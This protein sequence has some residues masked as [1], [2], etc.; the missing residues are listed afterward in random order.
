MAC[1]TA[2]AVESAMNQG[3]ADICMID[4]QSCSA[5]CCINTLRPVQR[6]VS[7]TYARLVALCVSLSQ[8][9][10]RDELL[11]PVAEQLD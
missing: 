7:V 10:M 1:S 2:F 5:A 3:P 9:L 11:K 4:Q 8:L 6:T